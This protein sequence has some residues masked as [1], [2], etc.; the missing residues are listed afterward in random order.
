MTTSL[1]R[2]VPT[3]ELGHLRFVA[4]DPLVQHFVETSGEPLPIVMDD[5]LV[6]FDAD[7]AERAARSIEEL[8]GTCQVIYF[9]CHES[10]P[11]EADKEESLRPVKVSP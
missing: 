5:I 3:S 1:V 6:N 2:C 11:L 7:R 10:T 9:T 8:S 4:D